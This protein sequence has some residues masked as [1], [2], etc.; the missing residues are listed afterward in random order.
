M[1]RISKLTA[2][3]EQ[4][5]DRTPQDEQLCQL[6]LTICSQ[7]RDSLQRR[8]S[9][10]RLLLKVQRLPNLSKSFHPDALEAV[11]KTWE[12]LDN[13]LHNFHPRSSPIRD[14]LVTWI[15]GNLRYRIRDLYAAKPPNMVSLDVIKRSQ[16]YHPYLASFDAYIEQL[17]AEANQSLARNI[18]Q[19]INRDPEAKLRKCYPKNRPDCNCQII[20][21]RLFLQPS[22]EKL[23]VIARQLNIN[24]QTIHSF[25]RRTGFPKVRSIALEIA[26]INS[27]VMSG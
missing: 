15:N 18:A 17:E 19:Y 7:P 2:A 27:D 12:W 22:P 5:S 1:E 6:I 26:Q 14:S 10:N 25:W 20:V 24:T 8:K 16:F 3:L 13:N 9:M 11:N 4:Y 23:S 21:Q